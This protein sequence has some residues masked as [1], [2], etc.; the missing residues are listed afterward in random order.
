MFRVTDYQLRGHNA[1]LVGFLLGIWYV[2]ESTIVELLYEISKSTFQ[3]FLVD[4]LLFRYGRVV[5]RLAP[6]IYN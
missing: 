5:L 4:S 6:A 3:V 2:E 1:G